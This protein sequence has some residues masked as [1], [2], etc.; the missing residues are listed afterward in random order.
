MPLKI[1][2]IHLL[3]C[4]TGLFPVFQHWDAVP[5][6]TS[7][8]EWVITKRCPFTTVLGSEHELF[9]INKPVNLCL[10]LTY[11]LCPKPHVSF[12]LAP[13]VFGCLKR[14]RRGCSVW[15]SWH[16][17]PNKLVSEMAQMASFS[18]EEG[19]GQDGFEMPSSLF[20]LLLCHFKKKLK[21]IR[22][23]MKFILNH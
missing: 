14:P 11:V 17:C 6:C 20:F 12:I 18:L 21:S 8:L 5:N 9:K 2:H 16:L 4:K 3:N 1:C 7:L 22:T 10:D 23:Q 13:L 19:T 15:M